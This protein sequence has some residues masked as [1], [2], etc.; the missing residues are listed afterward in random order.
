MKDRET[1]KERKTKIR[2]YELD[3]RMIKAA[4]MS[5]TEDNSISKMKTLMTP[6]FLH[7]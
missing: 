4:E 3:K 1:D 2:G 7:L 5:K 6:F